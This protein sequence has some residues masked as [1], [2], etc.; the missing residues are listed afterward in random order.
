[1]KNY[2]VKLPVKGYPQ[3][4]SIVSDPVDTYMDLSLGHFAF[5]KVKSDNIGVEVMIKEP[6]VNFKELLIS[7]KDIVK[8]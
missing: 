4:A 5:R 2:P 8:R 1:M 7:A 6:A 3:F